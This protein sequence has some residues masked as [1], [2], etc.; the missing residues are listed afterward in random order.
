MHE[1]ASDRG[2]AYERK[3]PAKAAKSLSCSPISEA[4]GAIWQADDYRALALLHNLDS[5]GCA[6]GRAVS[7]IR[8]GLYERALHE[9]QRRNFGSYDVDEAVQLA[10]VAAQAWG[11]LGDIDNAFKAVEL[12]V[13]ASRASSRSLLRLYTQQ[14]EALVA[15]IVKEFGHSREVLGRKQAAGA[16]GKTRSVMLHSVDRDDV[17]SRILELWAWHE[18]IAGNHE[19]QEAL[20]LSAAERAA[21]GPDKAVEAN[22]LAN[23]AIYTGTRPSGRAHKH[24]R[25]KLDSFPWTAHTDAARATISRELE[26]SVRLFGAT[27]VGGRKRAVPSLPARLCELLDS[28]LYQGWSDRQQFLA[29][30]RFCVSIAFDSNW[31]GVVCEITSLLRVAVLIA[32]FDVAL[33]KK[34][35]DIFSARRKLVPAIVFGQHAFSHQAL[36]EFVY[37][38][39]RKAEGKFDA[40]KRHFAEIHKFVPADGTN[41]YAAIAGVESYTM[42]QDAADLEVPTSFVRRFP[43]SSFSLRLREAL[44]IANN[45][46]G[47]DFPYLGMYGIPNPAA[48]R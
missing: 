17:E 32:P 47:P 42:T 31:S 7:S 6:I 25:G 30:S 3:L 44:A 1:Q 36:E 21:D 45:A 4:F 22:F 37:G 27:R 13:R 14:N 16:S 12:S 20:M 41:P 35:V 8:L 11:C 46:A 5:P 33:S 2:V 34:M 10:A 19:A 38:C 48:S 28:L 29:E 9:C 15:L 40:A 18:A 23:L 43:A 26:N 39:L 24:L